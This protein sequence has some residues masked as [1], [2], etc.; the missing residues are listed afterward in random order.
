MADIAMV[1]GTYNRL[2]LLKNAVESLRRGITDKHDL[3]MIIIDGGSTD[4]TV[5]W[6]SEQEDILIIRQTLPLTGAVKAFN[7]GFGLAVHDRHDYI[8]HFN[9]D[10]TL[11]TPGGLDRAI[12]IMEADPK[13]GEVAFQAFIN[14]PGWEKWGFDHVHGKTYGNFGLARREAGIAVAKAQGD[15]TGCAWWNPIYHTYGADS[16]FGAWL[17]K[18]GWIVAEGRDIK[19]W[20]HQPADDLRRR[21][22]SPEFLE[23]DRSHFRRRW[24]ASDAL[25]FQSV[26]P[27]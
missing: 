12:S 27:A 7:Q 26:I 1:F 2:S 5:E 4:G 10:A 18:L 24:G 8:G 16:E 25:E 23:S 3:E 21:N 20:E 14:A 11:E 22:H 6:L 19:V 13:V 9:D 15:P 17:W